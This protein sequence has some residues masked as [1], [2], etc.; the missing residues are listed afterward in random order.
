MRE[1]WTDEEMILTL[2]VYLTHESTDLYKSSEFLVE[3][4]NRLNKY[5]G[6]NRTPSSIEMRVANYKSVDSKYIKSGLTNGGKAVKEY[7]DRYSSDI[8]TMEKLYNEFVSLTYDINSD[9]D[10]EELNEIENSSEYVKLDLEEKDSYIETLLK[11][12]NKAIQQNFRKNLLL[13]FNQKCALCEINKA[14]L[15]IASHILPYSKCANKKDMVNHYNGLLLCPNH[16]AIFDKKLISFDEKGKILI[17]ADLPKELLQILNISENSH[18]SSVYLT[19]ERLEFLS[20][21]RKLFEKRK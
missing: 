3:F 9:N 2:Y 15:L 19:K 21:H 17:K 12:R 5:T 14:D 7:W 16:D 4:C 20:L 8:C 10:L 1:K 13:E 18:L 11:V 6:K